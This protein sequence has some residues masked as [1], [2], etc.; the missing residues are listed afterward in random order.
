MKRI[1][2]SAACIIALASC[3]NNN[4]VKNAQDKLSKAIS[5]PSITRNEDK[6]GAGTSEATT[7]VSVPEN[8]KM[9]WDLKTLIR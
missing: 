9:G 7:E 4:M 2:F 8:P 3:T 1:L 6:V 5:M